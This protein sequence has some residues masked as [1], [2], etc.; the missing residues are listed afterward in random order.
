[1]VLEGAFATLSIIANKSSL[2]FFLVTELP[3]TLLVAFFLASV[4][5]LGFGLSRVFVPAPKPPPVLGFLALAMETSHVVERREG[6]RPITAPG[7]NPET[8]HSEAPRRAAATRAWRQRSG[9]F[10][11]KTGGRV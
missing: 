4:F 1:M 3:P 9:M 6:R 10:L 11:S 8:L 5:F 7:L 2:P